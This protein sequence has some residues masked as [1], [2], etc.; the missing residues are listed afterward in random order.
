MLLR[1]LGRL[2]SPVARKACPAEDG[3]PP[4]P[5][6]RKVTYGLRP[7]VAFLGSL[8]TEG[9]VV[10]G[11][12]ESPEFG[13]FGWVTDPEGNRIELWQPSEGRFPG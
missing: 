6:P 7:A 1:L 4:P 11:E 10:D 2:V 13:R 9:C 5:G 3:A 12:S 8:K